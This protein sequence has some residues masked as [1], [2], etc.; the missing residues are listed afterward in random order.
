[1][2]VCVSTPNAKPTRVLDWGLIICLASVALYTILFTYWQVLLYR[3]LHMGITDLGYFDQSMYN[4]LHGRVLQ[5]SFDVPSPYRELQSS[6]SPHLFAQH[7]FVLML[8]LVF[9]LYALVPH[10]YTLFF[11]QAFAAAIGALPIYLLDRELMRDGEQSHHVACWPALAISLAYLLHPTLQ[12]ITVNMFTFG[13]HPENL[14]PPL[15]LFAFYFLHRAKWVP[16]GLFFLLAVLVVESYTLVCAALGI[17]TMLRWPRRRWLGLAMVL[18]SLFWLVLSLKVIVPH[19]KVGGG[20]PWFVNDMQ[21]GRVILDN[22][23]RV[24]S[25]VAP[26][27]LEYMAYV[28]GPFLFLPVPGIAVSAIALPILA[29]NFSALLIG[30]G[31]P[32]SYT[33]WQSNPVVPVTAMGAVFGLAWLRRRAPIAR[34]ALFPAAIVAVALGCDLWYGPLPVSLAI[35]PDQYHVDEGKAAAIARLRDIIPQEAVLSADYYLGS[36]FTSRQWLYWFPD[37]F[38]DADYVLI[39]RT[40][41]W[42]AVYEQPLNYLAHSPYHQVAFDEANVVLYHRAADALPP[43]AHEMPLNFGNQVQLLGYTIEPAVLRPG[44]TLRVIFYWQSQGPTDVSYTV[45]THLLDPAGRQVSQED[46]MPMSNLHPTT[47]WRPDEMIADGVYELP[48]P[49]DAP[50]GEYTVEFGLYNVVGG[51]R[52]D[53]LD[54]L[55]NP[56]DARALLSGIRVEAEAHSEGARSSVARVG[57]R[58][59]TTPCA[60]RRL[61]GSLPEPSGDHPVMASEAKQSQPRGRV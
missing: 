27:F 18:V 20:S 23:G 38:A 36:Q 31:A 49:P 22:L 46:S 40:S 21:G 29:V 17:Y 55:G 2:N 34:H 47:A 4:T 35:R 13:F 59:A 60:T 8:V 11:I 15:F 19:F 32:A 25:V 37:R 39:D 41:E 5:V 3:G 57:V 58:M 26:A 30:Y 56:Q 48:I 45:F 53:V 51:E 10:T 6:N 33:G 12:F 24:P 1:M 54:H 50:P 7:P 61:Q 9:P 16:F 43:L 14:F 52:L 44:D 42:T 28:L